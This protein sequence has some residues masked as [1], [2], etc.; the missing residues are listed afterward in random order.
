MSTVVYAGSFDPLTIGHLNIIEQAAKSFQEVIV[1]VATN[2]EKADGYMFSAISRRSMIEPAVEHLPNVKTDILKGGYTV[3]Y[4]ER[5][6]ATSL[7]RGLRDKED[8]KTEQ[9]NFIFNNF[10]NSSI[11]TVF[12]MAPPE[13]AH[14]SSS[15][16]KKHCYGITGWIDMVEKY[17]PKS[18]KTH[19][20][21]NYFFEIYEKYVGEVGVPCNLLYSA[22]RRKERHYH[23]VSHIIRMHDELTD[24]YNYASSQDSS[25]EPWRRIAMIATLFHDYYINSDPMADGTTRYDTNVL[26]DSMQKFL[27]DFNHVAGL[28][29]L[30]RENVLKAILATDN[31]LRGEGCPPICFSAVADADLAIFGQSPE[32]YDQYAAGIRAEYAFA[33]DEDFKAGRIK[34]LRKFLGRPH[35]YQTGF[36]REKYAARARANLTRELSSLQV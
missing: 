23:D 34:V 6:G 29:F 22:Y 33:S 3:D 26:N 11:S 8:F 19:L 15:Y 32:I 17:V 28:T 27:D 20:M 14:I 9:Q 21:S 12:L 24:F 30:D 18:V 10:A 7:V 35:I 31:H 5:V 4:A 13:I 2:P 36:F 25:S 16:V 1:L